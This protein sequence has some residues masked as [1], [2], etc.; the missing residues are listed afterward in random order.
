MGPYGRAHRVADIVEVHQFILPSR[1]Q[2]ATRFTNSHDRSL[3]EL[4]I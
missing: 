2:M 1:Y 4:V 3:F